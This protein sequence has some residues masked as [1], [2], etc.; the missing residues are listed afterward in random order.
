MDEN[1]KDNVKR[2]EMYTVREIR[3]AT[4]EKI[5]IIIHLYFSIYYGCIN[6]HP[7]S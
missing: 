2:V 7:V 1:I 3:I 5:A 4:K 6:G